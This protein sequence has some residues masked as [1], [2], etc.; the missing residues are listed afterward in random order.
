MKILRGS[1]EKTGEEMRKGGSG[2][3]ERIR[4]GDSVTAGE[5]MRWVGGGGGGASRGET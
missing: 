5:G 1:K 2:N 4:R 3:K